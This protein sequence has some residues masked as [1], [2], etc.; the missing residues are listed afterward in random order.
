MQK[1][2]SHRVMSYPFDNLSLLSL[3]SFHVKIIIF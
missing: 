1:K 2:E 3:S